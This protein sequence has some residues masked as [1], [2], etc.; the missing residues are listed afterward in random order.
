MT[1][2]ELEARV[3]ELEAQ[4]TGTGVTAVVTVP[5]GLSD[6]EVDAKIALVKAEYEAKLAESA[7]VLAG[8][9]A[10]ALSLEAERD[11][12][13]LDIVALTT[14]VDKVSGELQKKISSPAL[15]GDS[16]VL[17]GVVQS[18]L[19]K[20][21]MLDLVDEFRKKEIAD[22]AMVLVIQPA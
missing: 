9:T 7:D 19:K 21:R 12:L 20:E 18:I 13:Q 6:E 22:D 11:A 8:R 5:A 1:K 16:V 3:A 10:R 17:G 2:Q 4:I 15:S 14:T